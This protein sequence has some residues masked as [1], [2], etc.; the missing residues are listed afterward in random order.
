VLLDNWRSDR[1]VGSN[2]TEFWGAVSFPSVSIKDRSLLIPLVML[3][4]CLTFSWP[5]KVLFDRKASDM[6]RAGTYTG[7]R[8]D[9]KGSM[10]G[11][12][13]M[14]PRCVLAVGRSL[15]TAA[16]VYPA[17]FTGIVSLV[18]CSSLDR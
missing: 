16:P 12:R 9:A 13:R 14:S 15:G 18:I 11:M 2:Q 8:T 6:I 5:N 7:V 17:T 10:T 4:A 3:N 1:K